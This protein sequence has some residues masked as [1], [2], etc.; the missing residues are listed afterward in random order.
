MTKVMRIWL[1]LTLAMIF[2][3]MYDP[4]RIWTFNSYIGRYLVIDYK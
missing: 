4:P 2:L 1:M 3:I